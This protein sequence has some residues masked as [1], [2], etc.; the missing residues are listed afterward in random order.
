[1][2]SEA[3]DFNFGVIIKIRDSLCLPENGTNEESHSFLTDNA[4]QQQLT[5]LTDRKKISKLYR[6]LSP[7]RIIELVDKATR[8]DPAYHPPNFLNYYSITCEDE[9]E[10]KE[11]VAM[12]NKE[13]I[14]ELAYIETHSAC[15]PSAREASNPLRSYQEYLNP[16][17]VGID[18]NYAWGFC[19]GNGSGRVKFIDIEQGWMFNHED[20]RI[21]QLP[22]TGLNH[23]LHQDHGAAV[24]GIIMMQDNSVG[25]I[26]ITPKAEGN[27][28]SQWRP[29]GS[30]NTADAIMAAIDHLGFGDVLLLEAQT[31]DILYTQGVWPVEILDAT[32]QAIRLATALG[33]VVVEAAGNGMN[34][35]GN[36][37]D[38]F[39]DSNFKNVL[40]RS[41][42]HFKDSGAIVVAG[43]SSG[44]PHIKGKYS[45][46]GS[47]IDCYAWGEN[48]VTAGISPR[49]SG[50]SINTYSAD[51]SGT[52]SAS[53]IIAGAAIAVQSI[54][55]AK[56]DR[57]IGSMQ[58]RKL[59]SSE[60]Y[61][62]NSA[63]GHPL[64]K[65]GVM[66]DLKKIIDHGINSAFA[67]SKTSP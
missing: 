9:I 41:S 40:N 16:A 33:I 61:G 4:W 28:I 43:A 12:F 24:L 37:L 39:I 2:K 3:T 25:G 20:I 1:M 7:E 5:E 64:D 48:V 18:A 60:M 35:M 34:A 36:D 30:F 65:I 10:A 49:S 15:S 47:R 21:S 8:S 22:T 45:N 50:S 55:E 42:A 57:R 54:T 32:F 13:D 67:F 6:T 27:V 58:M 19:G 52:S 46:F 44:M 14:I 51:F 17:P 31:F 23:Y 56:Y 63:N 59:L 66:P 29:N 38:I 62:T 53:A 26:G 11:M